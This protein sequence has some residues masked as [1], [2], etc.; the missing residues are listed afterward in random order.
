MLN[1]L[2]DV[3]RGKREAPELCYLAEVISAAI[4]SQGAAAAERGVSITADVPEGI[5]VSIERNRIE[6][7]FLNLIGNA[8]EAMP[9]GGEI[10][11]RAGSTDGGAVVEVADT[12][13]GI[14]EH[15]RAQLFQP[16]VTH[17]K[18]SGLGLGLALARQAVLDHGGDMWVD[19]EP[20]RGARFHVRLPLEQRASKAV[21]S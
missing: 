2:A 5:E 20:G 14:S 9:Q 4:D 18:R 16:F 15:I 6:R 3:T 1:E 21:A 8:M 13:P 11:I 7:V 19:S 17:G 10:T 12:G